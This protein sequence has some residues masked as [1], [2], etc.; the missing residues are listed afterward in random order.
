MIEK[1]VGKSWSV[2]KLCKTCEKEETSQQQA[3][4]KVLCANFRSY[5]LSCTDG[6]ESL[7]FTNSQH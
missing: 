7:A 4:R 3:K 6:H 1:D 2:L 5:S